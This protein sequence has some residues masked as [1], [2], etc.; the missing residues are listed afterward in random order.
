MENTTPPTPG[1]TVSISQRNLE[2]IAGGLLIIYGV[3]VA[4]SVFTRVASQSDQDTTGESLNMIAAHQGMFL[5][6]AV[7]NLIS[8]FLLIALAGIL[9]LALRRHEAL[10][11]LLGSL[12]FLVAAT[13]WVISGIAGLS[14]ITLAAEFVA[15]SG[16][17]AES[18]VAAAGSTELLRE[19]SGKA[20]F[21]L[22]A[23]ALL[24]FGG[25]I[26][27]R[28]MVPRWLGWLGIVVGLLML[29][30]W[31]DTATL[32]HRLGGSGY[33]LWAALLGIWLL[34]KGTREAPDF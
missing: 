3:L 10:L 7:I 21:T 20:S 33:L 5:T 19:L 11:T 6:S 22:A 13:T 1:V 17:L 4:V 31:V 18:T 30:I 15:A 14:L 25:A 32:L 28:G 34:S 9:Y 2:R 26:S 16:S 23:L 12:F 29:F 27:W 8:N 24:A